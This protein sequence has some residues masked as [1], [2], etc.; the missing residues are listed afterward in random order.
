M[1]FPRSVNP[2]AGPAITSFGDFTA[3]GELGAAY[4][5]FVPG[6]GGGMQE[7]LQLNLPKDRISDR[8][9]LLSSLDDGKRILELRQRQGMDQLRSQAFEALLQGVS[10]AF[11]WRHEDPAVIAR[12]DTAP[13]IRPE[14]ISKKWNNHPHYV[15]HAT[16]LGKLLLLARRLC[17]RGCGFVTVT[18]SF[19]WDMHADI[20]NAPMDEGMGYVGAPFDHALAALIDDLEARGL[21]DRVMVV[22]CGEMGRTPQLNPQ[23]GRDHWGNLAPLIM[24]GG[25]HRLGQVI[26]QSSRDG[27][28][29]ASDPVTIAD[30][31]STIMHTFWI[32]AKRG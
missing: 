16:N 9:L 20:N 8:R 21:R 31:T 10:E 2:E 14:Q 3:A 26:G 23:G 13:L 18:T 5:P 25:G 29:P 30:L 11:D 1:L 19:V 27:G 7:D 28:E 12:Y 4:S 32:S 22:C 17:E 15:D 6:A 24:Y